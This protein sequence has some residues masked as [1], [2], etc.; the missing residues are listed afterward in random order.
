MHYL[1][2]ELICWLRLDLCKQIVNTTTQCKSDYY[3]AV[4]SIVY[5]ILR[6]KS[7]A[8]C[9]AYASQ[10]ESQSAR[11]ATQYNVPAFGENFSSQEIPTI[12]MHY[13]GTTVQIQPAVNYGLVLVLPM[14]V[15]VS[16]KLIHWQVMATSKQTVSYN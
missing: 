3:A 5:G 8:T 10:W 13:L 6:S 1:E 14:V 15:K 2:V 12:A 16:E 7:I 9:N 11:A 4:E